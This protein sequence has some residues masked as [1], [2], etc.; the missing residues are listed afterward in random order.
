MV[1]RY[2]GYKP[3]KEEYEKTEAEPLSPYSISLTRSYLKEKRK[4]L[5]EK[6]M[7][8]NAD[9]ILELHDT[10]FEQ[11]DLYLLPVLELYAFVFNKRMRKILKKYTPTVLSVNYGTFTD[12][13]IYDA[14]LVEIFHSPPMII[15]EFRKKIKVYQEITNLLD[16]LI[17]NYRRKTKDVGIKAK[18]C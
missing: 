3:E 7:Q 15:D 18:K 17:H 4:W 6:L 12:S 13:S 2:D 1:L 9:F 11:R 14:V 10:P 16:Y 8:L 5:K